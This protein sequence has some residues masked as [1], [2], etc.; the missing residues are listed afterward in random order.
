MRRM[1]V[2]SAWCILR[3]RND[4]NAALHDWAAAVALRRGSRVATVALARKLAG[5]LFAMWRDET[6]F[7]SDATAEV[8]L[9]AA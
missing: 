1:L 6:R 3:R 8:E 4:T 5:I 9:A 7:V 2:E